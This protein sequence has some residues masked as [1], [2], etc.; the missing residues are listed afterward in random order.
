MDCYDSYC[1][2]LPES[3]QKEVLHLAHEVSMAGHLGTGK[4]LRENQETFQLA[5]DASRHFVL[6]VTQNKQ[7]ER[8]ISDSG[9]FKTKLAVTEIK[10]SL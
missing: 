8:I 3:F 9:K 1:I 4:T 5:K 6:L 2:R 7:F 10:T